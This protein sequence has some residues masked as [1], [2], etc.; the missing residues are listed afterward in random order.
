MNNDINLK[1]IE[2]KAFSS[3]YQDGLF[4][5]LMGLLLIALGL[6]PILEKAYPL[7]DWWVAILIVPFIGAFLVA[8]K[9]FTVPRMGMV[10][11]SEKRR[12]KIKKSVGILLAFLLLGVVTFTLFSLGIIPYKGLIKRIQIPAIIAI[13]WATL[14][15]I[16]FSLLAYCL[17]IKRYYLYGIL[18]A[19][20]LPFHIFLKYNP[21]FSHLSLMMFFI[22][23]TIIIIAG[24]IIFIRFMQNNP[25]PLKENNHDE[26]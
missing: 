23:G 15:L 12:A 11:F 20:P 6:S 18:F 8:K 26:K 7:A 24:L 19:L 5:L 13:M 1:K 2:K 21:R 9:F 4:D 17:D 22:S 25:I 14:Q 3:T 16:G 10:K